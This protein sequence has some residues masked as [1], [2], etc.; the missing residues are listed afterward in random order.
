MVPGIGQQQERWRRPWKHGQVTEAVGG[1][2]ASMGKV[3]EAGSRGRKG[4]PR[5]AMPAARDAE[6]ARTMES[7]GYRSPLVQ[8][9]P[10]DGHVCTILFGPPPEPP[11]AHGATSVSS[12]AV[13][14]AIASAVAAA[15]AAAVAAS[16]SNN[17]GSIQQQQLRQQCQRMDQLQAQL[18]QQ[19]Q[20]QQQQQQLS[21][22]NSSCHFSQRLFSWCPW[23]PETIFRRLG[24]VVCFV[25]F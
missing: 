24:H 20:W 3:S 8:P 25:H 10:T 22:N 21:S 12:H 11:E 2:R 4:R 18:R 1:S 17:N 15:A 6:A 16:S 9:E 5:A 14:A 13:A 23:C 7:Q 19:W